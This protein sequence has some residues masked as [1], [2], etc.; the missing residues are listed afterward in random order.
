MENLKSSNFYLASM[1]QK[2]QNK[3]NQQQPQK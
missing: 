1:E 3:K 2:E